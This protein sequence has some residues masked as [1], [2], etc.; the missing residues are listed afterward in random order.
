MIIA[1]LL[2]IIGA[3]IKQ[4]VY[5][6][7]H[8]HT[9]FHAWMYDFMGIL[10][11]IQSCFQLVDLKTFARE[12]SHYDIIAKQT[13][14]Y[15]YAYPFIGLG[16]GI[17]YLFRCHTFAINWIVLILMLLGAVGITISLIKK[18]EI[19]CA[20]M[21]AMFNVPMTYFTLFENLFMAAMAVMMLYM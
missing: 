15:A 6:D 20:C 2:A 4:L 18:E 19:R 7:A 21:G 16:L 8:M 11:I 10:F 13:K 5:P 3:Y 1:Y 17:A 9:F 12:F 14:Y